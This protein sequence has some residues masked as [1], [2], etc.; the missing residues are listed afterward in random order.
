MGAVIYY[1]DSSKVQMHV[2]VD[3]S[4]TLIYYHHFFLY[5][6]TDDGFSQTSSQHKHTRKR[7]TSTG[8]EVTLVSGLESILRDTHGTNL[9]LKNTTETVVAPKKLEQSCRPHPTRP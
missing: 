7:C 3:D 6:S 5:E 1:D 8:K 4:A 2:L 9:L